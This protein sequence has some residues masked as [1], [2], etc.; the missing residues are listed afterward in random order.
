MTSACRRDASCVLQVGHAGLCSPTLWAQPAVKGAL[1]PQFRLNAARD[2]SRDEDDG[3][4]DEAHP[5]S[6]WCEA[7]NAGQRGET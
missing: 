6:G 1:R 7:F 3:R 4:C 5:D 2:A